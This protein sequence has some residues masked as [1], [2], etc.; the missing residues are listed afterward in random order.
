MDL[1]SYTKHSVDVSI[2]IHP[3][4]CHSLV[5]GARQVNHKDS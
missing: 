5:V 4:Y 2:A 1:F 3:G